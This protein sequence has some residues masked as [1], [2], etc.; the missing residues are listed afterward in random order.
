MSKAIKQFFVLAAVVAIIMV[1]VIQFRPGTNVEVSGGP[2]CAFEISGDCVPHSDFVA[3]YRLAAPNLEPEVLKQWRMR[4]IVV[5]GLMERWLLVEDAKRLGL[6]VSDDDIT[7][8]LVKGLARFSL[9]AAREEDVTFRLARATGGQIAP[10]PQGPARRMRVHDPKTGKFDYDKYKRWVARMSNKTLAD[11]REF[12]R[13]E[14]I[15]A[16][17]RALIRTRVRVSEKEAFAK[18]ARAN[19]RAVVDYLKLERA[20]YRDYVIDRSDEAVA[21][22]GKEHA[23]EVDEAWKARK[24]SYLPECRKAR[25]IL[26]RVDAASPNEDE[27]KKDARDKAAALRKRIAGGDA[28]A[29][30]AREASQD[31]NTAADGGKLGCFAAGK[32]SKPNTAKSVDDAVFA[33]EEGQL[34]ELVETD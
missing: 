10:P 15:A 2:R 11:F 28:F 5:Q 4:E 33:L 14:Q 17:M 25:H 7:R 20:Y 9:P 26:V 12:Q 13:A 6:T 24:E 30:V 31:Q 32:L 21:K 22:W 1:F 29:E 16:Q 27:A 19:E 23:E 18:F 8:H 34:S 3:A